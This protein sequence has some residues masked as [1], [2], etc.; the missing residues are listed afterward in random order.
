[1]SRDK[2]RD[3]ITGQDKGKEKNWDGKKD[4]S[5]IGKLELLKLLILS[6]EKGRN[7]NLDYL[8]SLWRRYMISAFLWSIF[9]ICANSGKLSN[10]Q[11]QH[12]F[13]PP[14]LHLSAWLG[15]QK[16]WLY[17]WHGSGA[18]KI[19]YSLF[20]SI[21]KSQH[22]K[23]HRN[24]SKGLPFINDARPWASK[25][26]PNKKHLGPLVTSVATLDSVGENNRRGDIILMLSCRLLKNFI[27]FHLGIYFPSKNMEEGNAKR[28]HWP[29]RL[30]GLWF[31][32]H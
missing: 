6:A 14:L 11:F 24:R 20:I 23:S 28:Y 9:K 8:L 13:P 27:L 26:K 25:S 5:A 10:K 16:V 32:K 12:V 31:S 29:L 3:E 30:F 18:M 7:G 19:H 17:S 22:Q 1:M 15:Q 4:D 21:W 2:D